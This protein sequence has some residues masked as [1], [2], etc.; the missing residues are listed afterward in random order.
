[1]AAPEQRNIEWGTADVEDA[2]LSVQL[3]GA[4]SKAWKQRFGSVLTLLDARHSRWGEV[5]LNKKG[6]RVVEVQPGTESELRHFGGSLSGDSRDEPHPAR[7][8]LAPGVETSRAT[9]ATGHGS[10]Y[11]WRSKKEARSIESGPGVA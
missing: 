9:V 11:R 8:V 3:T 4:S 5:H 6:I 1:M 10:P 2:T 7:I